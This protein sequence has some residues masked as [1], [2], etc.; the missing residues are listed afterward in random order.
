MDSLFFIKS[1][2]SVCYFDYFNVEH[3]RS[4]RRN[5]V[6]GTSVTVCEIRRQKHCAF[7]VELHVLNHQIKTGNHVAGCCFK[8]KI[9]MHVSAV[10]N[11]T[12]EEVTL[13]FAGYVLAFSDF[14]AFTFFNN[15]VS[16]IV[17][18]LFKTV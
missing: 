2:L 5:N 3:N 10:K 13:V 6:S 11:T 9:I 7:F 8:F 1:G 12:V 16:E 18:E 17:L 15:L 14:V 4:I